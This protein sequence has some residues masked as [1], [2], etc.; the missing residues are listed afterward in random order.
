MLG[1]DITGDIEVS[2]LFRPL[3]VDDAVPVSLSSLLG[4]HAASNLPGMFARVRPSAHDADLRRLTLEEVELGFADG[5]F[6]FTEMDSLLPLKGLFMFNRAANYHAACRERETIFTNTV[7]VVP[8]IM[9]EVLL[10]SDKYEL[11][12]ALEQPLGFVIGT[13]DMKH[14]YRQSPINPAHRCCSWVA[15]WDHVA[16]SVKFIVLNG[17]RSSSF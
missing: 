13:E 8:A 1:Y 6:D 4:Q 17:I 14:A 10:L 15:F 11:A 12:K 7:D 9:R 5:P 16:E 3:H 2:G